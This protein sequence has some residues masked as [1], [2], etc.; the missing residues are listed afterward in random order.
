MTSTPP[1]SPADPL[2]GSTPS[3]SSEEALQLQAEL[4][5]LLA[6]DLRGPITVLRSTF[7]L[8]PR[9]VNQSENVDDLVASGRDAVVRLAS[10]VDSIIV[11]MDSGRLSALPMTTRFSVEEEVKQALHQ[12]RVIFEAREVAVA[13]HFEG[14]AVWVPG[15][16]D[17][18]RSAIDNL[19]INAVEHSPL[20]GEISVILGEGE[21]GRVEVRVSDQGP[22]IPEDVREAVF[23]PLEFPGL[24]T[25]GVRLG[26]GLG[27]SLARL[28]AE[29]HGGQLVCANPHHRRFNST[30]ILSLPSTGSS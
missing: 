24:K 13:T 26:R 5:R 17:L 25:R 16:R 4:V 22:G 21:S 7:S 14:E 18:I 12:L 30:F 29:H 27:L 6:H 10:M 9:L 20:G 8:L 2:W 19:L 11:G 23:S 28:A 15:Q 3:P 1:P